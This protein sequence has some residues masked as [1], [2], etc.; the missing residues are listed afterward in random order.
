MGDYLRPAARGAGR[1]RATV[2]G[3]AL[4]RDVR[5]SGPDEKVARLRG[6]AQ[7]ARSGALDV[8]HL[9]EIGAERAYEEVQTI[10][11][12]GPFYAGLVVLRASGFADAMLT[13]GERKVLTHAARFYRLDGPPTLERL[14]EI[15]ESWRPFRTW[16]TVLIR[17]AGDRAARKA[18]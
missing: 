13:V 12:L 18:V 9:H 17:L 6:V 16:T 1:S 4:R 15:A 11:G 8:D 7:A 2:A 5:A 10:K 14:I 3:R